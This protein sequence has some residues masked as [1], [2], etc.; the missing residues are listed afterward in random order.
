MESIWIW[1]RRHFEGFAHLFV[2]IALCLQLFWPSLPI[3]CH[4]MHLAWILCYLVGSQVEGLRLQQIFCGI[5]YLICA[6]QHAIQTKFYSQSFEI[7][8]IGGFLCFIMADFAW[9]YNVYYTFH[10]GPSNFSKVRIPSG[11]YRVGV[12]YLRS[13]KFGNEIAVFYPMDRT[14]DLEHKLNCGRIRFAPWF[15]ETKI[16]FQGL[17]QQY[18]AKFG[19]K[20]IPDFLLKCYTLLDMPAILNGDISLRF[21]N[22]R[23]KIRP[24]V[25]SHGLTAHTVNYSLLMIDLASHG[26]LVIQPNHLDKSCLGTKTKD[27]QPVVYTKAEFYEKELRTKQCNT[28]IEEI[29]AVVQEIVQITP[30]MHCQI[31]GPLFPNVQIDNSQLILA[32][33]SFGGITAFM[34]ASRGCILPPKSV[35]LIDPW[36][37]AFNEEILAG[38]EK[39]P[40]P[41][42]IINAEYFHATIPKKVFDSWSC[43]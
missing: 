17:K 20:N 39:C 15:R 6:I 3:L 31:F 8:T 16:T 12:R 9:L 21:G 37:Y 32:G 26:Y 34:A 23:D 25:F 5:F 2:L 29:Q 30:E 40:S 7:F 33:H 42:Q 28:R 24:I 38:T 18:G 11:K 13:E 22:G 41:L 1:G 14:Q 27:G 19:V 35:L 4:F 36:F 43:V 10:M